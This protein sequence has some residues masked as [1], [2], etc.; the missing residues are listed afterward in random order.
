MLLRHGQWE[1]GQRVDMAETPSQ[2]DSQS[3]D[4]ITEN[5]LLQKTKPKLTVHRTTLYLLIKRYTTEMTT[6]VSQS[7]LARFWYISLSDLAKYLEQ[8]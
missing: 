7:I 1:R 3:I 8:C 4:S 5:I 2:S 6:A